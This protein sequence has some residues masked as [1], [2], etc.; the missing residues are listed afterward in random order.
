LNFKRAHCE[1]VRQLS[2][3]S[4]RCKHKTKRNYFDG[5]YWAFEWDCWWAWRVFEVE[6]DGKFMSCLICCFIKQLVLLTLINFT[7]SSFNFH[8]FPPLSTSNPPPTSSKGL[9][10]S[11]QNLQRNGSSSLDWAFWDCLWKKYLFEV[12]SWR[13]LFHYLHWF[14]STSPLELKE[15]LFTLRLSS[16]STIVLIE[17]CFISRNMN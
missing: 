15:S 9:Q 7:R 8:H 14:Y 1:G 4:W 10:N 2:V 11:K 3:P 5:C 16:P 6:E 13:G 12:R 17:V